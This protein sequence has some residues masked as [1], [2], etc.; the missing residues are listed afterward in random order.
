MAAGASARIRVVADRQGDL[1]A[2][3]AAE[4]ASLAS[5]SEND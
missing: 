4:R 3:A 2:I 1:V 5:R